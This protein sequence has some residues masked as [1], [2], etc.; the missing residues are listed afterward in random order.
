MTS[1]M[2][3]LPEPSAGGPGW[4]GRPPARPGSAPGPDDRHPPGHRGL[5]DETARRL[6]H[7]ELAVAQLLVAEGH[8]VRSLAASDRPTGDL[9][10]CGRETEI[11]SLRPGANSRTVT[12]ALRR[13]QDQGVDVI[14]DARQS[15]LLR[16]AAER[17]VADFASR[18][19]RGR[20][21]RIRV[22]GGDF[23]RTYGR[24][25]IHR[26]GR[27]PGGPRFEPGVG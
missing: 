27:R 13:A 23:D 7:E 6:S 3:A 24:H 4:Y 15:G 16:L 20:V 21:E 10:V 17:G 26:L 2:H 22:L 25:D 8:Q 9:R 12:N 11:K 19:Q 14:I 5:L 18:T 1:P